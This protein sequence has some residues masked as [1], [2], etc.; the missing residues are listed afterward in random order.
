MIFRRSKRKP[1]TPGRY[2]SACLDHL[3][4]QL[5]HGLAD[6]GPE[7]TAMWLSSL[8][9]RT[10][11]PL[12]GRPADAPRR[13]YRNIDAP[14]GSTAYWDFPLMVATRR[15][16]DLTDRPALTD[17]VHAYLR[18]VLSRCRAR[19][20]LLL[21]GNHYFWDAGRGCVVSFQC[22]EPPEPVDVQRESGSLHEA[23][24][25]PPAWDLL[26]E[27]DAEATDKA[28]AAMG[29]WH[30]FD[31]KCG[32]FNRHADR[33]PGCAFLE[34]GGILVES[35]CWQAGRNRDHKQARRQVELAMKIAGFSWVH[36]RK[37][38]DLPENNPT[39]D[40][41]DKLVCTTE[42][43]L[44]AGSLLRAFAR[45]GQR[46]FLAVAYKAMAA[47][48]KHG[49]DEH[50]RLYFGRLNVADGSADLS[51]PSTAYMPGEHADNYNALF[52]THDYPLALAETCA[53]LLRITGDEVFREGVQRFAATLADL[54][55]PTRPIYAES[56]GR[57]I[58]FL[59]SAAEVSKAPDL[60]SQAETLADWA[61][62]HL[63]TDT[64]FRTH[65]GEDRYDAVDG[66]GLLMLALIRLETGR[67]PDT[68]GF[69]F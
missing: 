36:R 68:M 43:G 54:P 27:V 17:A 18:D 13:V 26:A 30:V 31:P 29:A 58:W 65:T 45:T 14:G 48:L 25:L 41:W 56:L 52:P 33:H 21:W 6:H 69:G 28:I 39:W 53:Q 57:A 32:G 44:W 61:L 49:Y 9:A 67:T 62:E 64:L 20:G 7:P 66:L 5:R 3:D 23:R 11:Q 60:R 59:L 46:E 24:P 40:R 22:D 8:D 19:N 63:W 47:Y 42:V 15:L 37:D 12:A 38:V 2:L 10:A 35:L 51:E 16:G 4:A 55:D 1:H 34:S 50:T